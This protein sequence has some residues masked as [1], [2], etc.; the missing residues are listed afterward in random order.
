MKNWKILLFATTLLSVVGCETDLEVLGEYEDNPV[1]FGILDQNQDTQFVRVNKAFLGDADINQM[2]NN[3]DSINYANGVIKVELLNS[4]NSNVIQMLPINK[5]K[6][7][8]FFD[9]SKNVVFYT[10]ENLSFSTTNG[11]EIS[12]EIVA[13]N[14]QTGTVIK[15]STNLVKNITLD[16]PRPAAR[17]IS[18]VRPADLSYVSSFLLEW[19]SSNNAVK[20]EIYLRFIYEDIYTLT[21][22]TVTQYYDYKVGN[23]EN[24]GG[25]PRNEMKATVTPEIFYKDLGQNLPIPPAQVVRIRPRVEIR[26]IAAN[27]DLSLYI[28]LNGPATGINQN[29]LAFS[30]MSNGI[31]LFAARNERSVFPR[32]LTFTDAS[33]TKLVEGDDTKHLKFKYE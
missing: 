7:G 25:N 4:S 30:N 8:G 15:G 26:M 27:E 5:P 18:L 1:V 32:E 13:T 10:T 28:D 22:D 11:N 24:V 6:E 17:E 29:Q 9:N 19:Q 14:T 20:H 23:R 3:P 16:L 33:E 31:G 12:Y 2:A 21:N